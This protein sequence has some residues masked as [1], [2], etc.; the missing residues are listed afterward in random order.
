MCGRVGRQTWDDEKPRVWM[1]SASVLDLHTREITHVALF[2]LL[3]AQHSIR[4]YRIKSTQGA[5]YAVP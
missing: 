2:V 5:G 4:G 3:P 1:R